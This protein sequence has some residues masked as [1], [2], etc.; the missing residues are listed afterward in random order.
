MTA[1]YDIGLAAEDDLEG[2][3]DLQDR[4][5][6]DR[7]GPVPPRMVRSGHRSHAGGGGAARGPGGG[8][9]R[10]LAPGRVR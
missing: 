6:P 5:Q 1:G 3:L 4:N 9:S 8:L 10:L 2:I 7:G